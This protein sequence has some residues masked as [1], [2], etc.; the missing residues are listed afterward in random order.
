MIAKIGVYELLIL[1]KGKNNGKAPQ[2]SGKK[3]PQGHTLQQL[4]QWSLPLREGQLAGRHQ[5]RTHSRRH[6]PLLLSGLDRQRRLLPAGQHHFRHRPTG[7]L[8]PSA[9]NQRRS[10]R[11]LGLDNDN[12]QQDQSGRELLLD[13]DHNVWGPAAVPLVFHVLPMVEETSLPAVRVKP[14]SI[15]LSG[16]DG[17]V[18]A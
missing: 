8:P 2:P 9:P 17:P 13:P 1:T 6:R 16:E 11:G 18:C 12:R 3:S 14:R 10:S 15:Q 5:P 7:Q 4:Q